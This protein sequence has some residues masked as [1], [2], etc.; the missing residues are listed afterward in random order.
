MQRVRV[1]ELMDEPNLA[2][3]AHRRALAGLARIN[4]LTRSANL[5]W[6]TIRDLAK[7]DRPHRDQLQDRPHRGQLQD[8][9]H[10][11][12][13]QDRPHR[14]QLQDRPH[15]GQL[16]V[17]DIATGSGDIPLQLWKRAKRCLLPIAVSG[18]DISTTAIE[19]A[20]AKASAAGANIDYFLHDVLRDPLPTDY[21]VVTCSLFLHH[22]DPPDVVEILRKMMLAAK[23]M[24]IVTDLVRSRAS[25]SLVWIASHLLSRSPIVRYDGPVSVR[26]AY[27]IRELQQM[28]AE[29]GMTGAIVENCFP[30]RMRLC[31][32]KS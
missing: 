25:Y 30:C 5:L 2:P 20:R 12:Q 14:G 31:W 26:A 1:P 8:R 9:P 29:A 13:L 23:T 15:R 7:R 16:Q 19:T 10:R 3:D 24:V 4:A 28:A 18:C 6:P 22:L 11:D 27:T 21:D 17:L 32:S